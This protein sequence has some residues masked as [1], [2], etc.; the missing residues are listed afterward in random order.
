MMSKKPVKS[1]SNPLLAYLLF[2]GSILFTVYVRIR[3]L[4]IPM[5]RDEGEFG[6][7]A[8][9]ILH[10]K[11]P[12]AAYYYKLPG[13]SY[14]YAFFM[15]VFGNSLNGIR[16]GLLVV[17]LGSLFVLF[18]IVRKSFSLHAAA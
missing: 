15:A 1:D 3:L 8:Q 10:G 2:A 5:E 6:Y 17:N 11:S 7:V 18:A 4:G 13:V 9:L 16:L 12:Y 14:I